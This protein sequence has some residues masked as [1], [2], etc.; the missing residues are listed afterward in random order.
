M[1]IDIHAHLWL[2]RYE[3]DKKDIIKAC[4]LYNIDKIYVSS[5]GTF[6]PSKQEIDELNHATHQF[7][8]E[9][10]EL[11]GG[12]CY[13]NPGNDNC[14]DILKKGIEEHGM[15]GMKLWVS[16]FCDDPKVYPLVEKCIEYKIPVLLHAFH[17][18]VDQLENESLGIN[19]ANLAQRYPEAK[20]IMAHLGANCY[21]GV[22]SIQ[23]RKNVSVDMSGSIYRRDDIDYTK[24]LIGAER[25]IFGSDLPDINVVTT[26]GQ[27]E[28]AKLT[29]EEKDLI[30]YKN[31]LKILNRK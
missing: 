9:K 25:I 14:M 20:I 17:K 23:D 16:T 7:M 3:E 31:A 24:K 4:E 22:K 11:V 13:I 8:Q 6:Y 30:Y 29:K 21:L 12:F 15:S 27:I 10:S 18:A 2:G 19:I 1:L 26:I 28:E 5:L